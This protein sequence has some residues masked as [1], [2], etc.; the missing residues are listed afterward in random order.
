MT[1]SE[2]VKMAEAWKEEERRVARLFQMRRR[3]L[4]GNSSAGLGPGD[5]M[6]RDGSQPDI[7]IEVKSWARMPLIRH[8]EKV[9]KEAKGL[10]WVL[11]I[12]EKRAKRRFA[13]CDV[14]MLAE[15][16]NAKKDQDDRLI[17][18]RDLPVWKGSP[19]E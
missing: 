8:I 3:P 18:V 4:S 7:V 5:V 14:E 12:H 1:W 2:V 17:P 6:N 10:P 16:W 9:Q 15:A 11:V 19:L 13:I